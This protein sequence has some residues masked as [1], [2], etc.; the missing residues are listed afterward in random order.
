MSDHNYASSIL[1]RQTILTPYLFELQKRKGGFT[2]TS[3]AFLEGLKINTSTL[4]SLC[5][6][7]WLQL[8]SKLRNEIS[9][10]MNSHI[11]TNTNYP[12]FQSTKSIM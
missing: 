4:R 5:K 12:G 1:Y 3:L 6:Y 9:L 8:V 2:I 10:D 7:N 11:K